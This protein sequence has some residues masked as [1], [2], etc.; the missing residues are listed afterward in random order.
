LQTAIAI[1][2]KP[3]NGQKLFFHLLN[4]TILNSY[5]FYK[6]REQLIRVLIL[7]SEENTEIHGVPRGQSS[8]SEIQMSRLE[9]KH[10]VHWSAKGGE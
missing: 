1:A 7:S 8:S 4:L 2:R 6:F 9:V 10:S 3:R 5:I